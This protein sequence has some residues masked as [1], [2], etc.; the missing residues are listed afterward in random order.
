MT[1]YRI[2]L[3]YA[4]DNPSDE[5]RWDALKAAVADLPNNTH[6]IAEEA[7][8]LGCPAEGHGA[9]LGEYLAGYLPG[10][11]DLTIR[12]VDEEDPHDP[13]GRRREIWQ[14]ASGGDPSR[15]IK[16]HLRRAF[17]RLVMEEMHRRG[18][19]VNV[20]VS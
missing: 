4:Y 20:V 16:H 5:R 3:G 10:S 18:I 14:A 7:V 8:R 9:G 19:E 13:P 15:S 12:V 2:S 11:T 6:R 1:S 17:C